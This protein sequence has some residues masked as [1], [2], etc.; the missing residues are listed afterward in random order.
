MSIPENL[1]SLNDA[2]AA[3]SVGQDVPCRRCGYNL[4]GLPLLSRCPECG[5]AVGVSVHGDLLRYSD[6]Q[7]VTTLHKG[8]RLMLWSIL[9]TVIGIVALLVTNMINRSAGL[10]FGARMLPLA[11]S[12]LNVIGAWL[13]TTPDPS[14]IGEDRYGTARKVIRFSLGA[15]VL[16]DIINFEGQVAVPPAVYMVLQ[17]VGGLSAVAGLVGL[18]AQ[19][20][21]LEKLATRLPSDALS[22]RS[23]RIKWG[24][25]IAYAVGISFGLL[26]TALSR[27]A[28]APASIALGGGCVAGLAMVAALVY[29]IMYLFLLLNFGRALAEQTALALRNWSSDQPSSAA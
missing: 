20:H 21:Y 5:T 8:V 15:A 14:G 23:R 2:L 12:V 29:G 22:D 13:L 1:A 3:A 6:P 28:G 9:V 17:V 25:S 10:S 19:L 7:F 18:F 16:N 4:R 24:L 27:R 26:A 11:G